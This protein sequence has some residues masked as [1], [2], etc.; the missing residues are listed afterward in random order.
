MVMKRYPNGIDGDFFFMKRAPAGRPAW[1]ETC[2]IEHRSGNVIDFPLIQDRAALVWVINLGCIDL[3][4]WYAP[5]AH[6]D[7]PEFLHFDLDPCHAGFDVVREAALIVRDA[8]QGLGMPVYAKTSGSDGMHLY[9]P[10]VPSLRQHDVW[11]VAKRIGVELA[12]AHPDVLTSEYSVEK[13]ARGR[14]L[15]DYNQNRLGA[16]LASVYSV[17]P[18]AYA[19]VSMPVEWDEVERGIRPEDFT[20]RNARERIRERGDRWKPLTQKRGRYDLA[21]LHCTTS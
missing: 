4:P 7:V 18:N 2:S 17:R 6:F 14:V 8:L 19:G 3:N 20:L 15:V 13:R 9:V 11:S 21:K 12:K 16:T 5:C 1:I 10:I